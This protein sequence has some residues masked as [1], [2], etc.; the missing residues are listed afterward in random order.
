MQ[1]IVLALLLHCNVKVTSGQLLRAA[2]LMAY[3]PRN[4]VASGTKAWDIAK[5]TPLQVRLFIVRLRTTNSQT[6]SV[7]LNV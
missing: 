4:S 7:S 1:F 3:V 6:Y 2:G 5:T